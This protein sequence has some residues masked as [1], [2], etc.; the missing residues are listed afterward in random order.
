MNVRQ[1]KVNLD[2]LFYL[3]TDPPPRKKPKS[4]VSVIDECL[5]MATNGL[6]VGIPCGNGNCTGCC[7]T[8]SPSHIV[9]KREW[10]D[11]GPHGLNY[12]KAASQ[13]EENQ[14]LDVPISASI[15]D[16]NDPAA[17][18]DEK[19]FQMALKK[20]KEEQKIRCQFCK[21]EKDNEDALIWHQINEC[22]IVREMDKENANKNINTLSGTEDE[23]KSKTED[24]V[25]VEK[26]ALRHTVLSGEDREH[27]AQGSTCP[28]RKSSR[29][30]KL[31]E[32][33][34]AMIEEEKKKKL[35]KKKQNLCVCKQHD[36]TKYMIGCNGSCKGWYHGECIGITE[37][38]SK[39]IYKYFCPRTQCQRDKKAAVEK[40]EHNKSPSKKTT[41]GKRKMCSDVCESM[42][43]DQKNQLLR[44]KND[45]I[46]LE[47][48][49]DTLKKHHEALRST[50]ECH[51][52]TIEAQKKIIEDS[53]NKIV[54]Q[55]R[56]IDEQGVE[57]QSHCK[58]ALSFMDEC[59][60]EGDADVSKETQKVRLDEMVSAAK[61]RV[62]VYAKRNAELEKEVEDIDRKM[63]EKEKENNSN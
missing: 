31:S 37:E 50:I 33:R 42:K 5:K 49:I 18:R 7:M 47:Q 12:L 14:P 1:C 30:T 21:I 53:N 4:G 26:S 39:G 11:R 25:D 44:Y 58:L 63:G 59:L 24:D 46:K 34:V 3:V 17:I 19:L 15:D 52:D 23:S 54:S 8:H 61:E 43:A 9:W 38:A 28:S 40:D 29:S 36:E 10:T 27:Q 55:K 45:N 16:P 60:D 51:V 56:L 48:D 32:K 35:E 6:F 13:T 2:D 62:S 20:S 41:S 57:L 22:K